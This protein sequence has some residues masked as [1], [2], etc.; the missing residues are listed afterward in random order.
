[1]VL[2]ELVAEEDIVSE[3]NSL[4]VPKLAPDESIANQRSDLNEDSVAS[5]QVRS[6]RETKKTEKG[7]PMFKC[8]VFESHE[9]P[10]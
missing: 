4:Q 8:I 10:A 6:D 1:L 5:F 2:Q 7:N 3:A 9:S